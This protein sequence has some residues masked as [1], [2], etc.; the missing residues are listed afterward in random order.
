MSSEQ[1]HEKL[2]Q[3]HA[4]L[5]QTQVVDDSTREI[6]ADLSHDIQELLDR[7]GEIEDDR[8]GSLA[9]RLRAS[10]TKFET[11]HPRLTGAMDRAIDALVQ[12]GV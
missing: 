8:Y 3:L 7:P 6:L 10:L 2:V 9:G 1:L 12:M 4:E 5:A 11:S